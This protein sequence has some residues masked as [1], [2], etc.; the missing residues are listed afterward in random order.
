MNHMQEINLLQNQLKDRSLIWQY[1]NRLFINILILILI[2]EG[3]GIVGLTILNKRIEKEYNKVKGGNIS[4]QAELTQKQT[5]LVSATDLQAQLKNLSYLIDSRLYWSNFFNEISKQ[6]FNK[7]RFTS[8]NADIAGK[9]HVEGNV[10]NY[11]DLGKLLLGLS[12]SEKIKNVKLLS[13]NPA[14]KEVGGYT[15]S[16]DFNITPDIFLK[17]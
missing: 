5:N 10:S 2:L 15:F 17:Q 1:R 3:L 16:L 13:S 14:N 12:T 9:V 11:T 6:T 4:L 8:L 7:A